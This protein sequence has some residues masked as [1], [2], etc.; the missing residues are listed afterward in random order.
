MQ[1]LLQNKLILVISALVVAGI[2]W[3]GLSPASATPDLI[4]TPI[5]TSGTKKIDQGIVQTLLSLHAVKLEGTIFS[6]TIFKQLKDF[7][8]EIVVEP[9]GRTNPFAP[10][11]APSAPPS[12][13]QSSQQLQAPKSNANTIPIFTPAN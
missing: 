3:Y 4:S 11:S 7:S 2:A 12:Q 5:A 1:T 9:A 13:P 6:N 8:T 10:L